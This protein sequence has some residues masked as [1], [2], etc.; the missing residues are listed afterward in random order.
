MLRLQTTVDIQTS[1]ARVWSLLMDFSQYPAWNPF[2]RSLEGEPLVSAVI[3]AFLQLPG[4]HAMRF[5]HWVVALVPQREFAGAEA[6]LQMDT[7]L[8]VPL[9]RRNL[10]GSTRRGFHAM[11]EALKREA[12]PS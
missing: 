10:Q 8:L 12:E 9:L 2:I 4:S 7:G 3:N 5:R 6:F 11:N 1:S